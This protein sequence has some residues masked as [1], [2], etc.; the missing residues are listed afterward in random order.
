MS[1]LVLSVSIISA[2]V[3][4]VWSAGLSLAN[5]SA[6]LTLLDGPLG[7]DPAFHVVC[8]GFRMMRRFPASGVL[9]QATV[10]RMLGEVVAGASVY[11]GADCLFY[12]LFLGSYT[13]CLGDA[14]SFSPLLHCF[15]LSVV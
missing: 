8:C 4:A 13:V 12:W 5:L 3:R 15:S 14:W 6:V 10:F 2:F 9:D 11:A 7:C 1:L